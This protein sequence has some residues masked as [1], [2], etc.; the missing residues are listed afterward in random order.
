VTAQVLSNGPR[1]AAFKLTYAPWDA[2]PASKL[3]ETQTITVDCGVNFD[4]VSS[5]FD[6]A[7]DGGVVGIGI[8]EHAP[9]EGFPKAVLTRDPNNRWMSLWEE[10][11]DGGLGVA[12]ILA[13]G[14]SAEDYAF[15][16]PARTPGNANHLLVFKVRDGVPVRY[17]T[18]AGWNR[19]GQF[20]D[21]ASWEN[22]VK[23]FAA[24]VARP[25][26][27]TVGTKP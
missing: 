26:T 14:T 19:S 2:G 3:Q 11:K 15:E 12:V 8:T 17:F 20:T 5:E 25:L 10:N 13:S 16:P 9:I 1:R 18:G 23:A 22:Y 7:D 24:G 4:S 27:I 21:R 6:F